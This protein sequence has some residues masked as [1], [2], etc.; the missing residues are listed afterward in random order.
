MINTYGHTL[1]WYNGTAWRRA[2]WGAVR[3]LRRRPYPF[4]GL[5][6]TTNH[7]NGLTIA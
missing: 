2:H 3:P 6:S 1:T 7:T 5:V 4:Q